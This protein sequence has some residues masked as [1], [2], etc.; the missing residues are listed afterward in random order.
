MPSYPETP[1]ECPKCGETCVLRVTASQERENTC[2]KCGFEFTDVSERASANYVGLFSE[3]SEAYDP[4]KAMFLDPADMERYLKYLREDKA[5]EDAQYDA[6]NAITA[7]CSAYVAVWNGPE[8]EDPWRDKFQ[9][10][11]PEELEDRYEPKRPGLEVTVTGADLAAKVVMHPTYSLF[12]G[13]LVYFCTTTDRWY[14]FVQYPNGQVEAASINNAPGTFPRVYLSGVH[15][16][17]VGAA[18]TCNG[19]VKFLT[20]SEFCGLG[21]TIALPPA[22]ANK[23]AKPG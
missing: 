5:D 13:A 7:R 21:G 11:V 8:D 16:A 10:F 3:C 19:S 22:E 4:P 15:A 12:D 23:D 17:V 18:R 1:S 20:W 14:L 6:R 2:P 9:P